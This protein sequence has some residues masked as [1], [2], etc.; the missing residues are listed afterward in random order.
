MEA[1]IRAHDDYSTIDQAGTNE[2][3]P[4]K[5]LSIILD[6][7]SNFQS[8]RLKQLSI[9]SATHYLYNLKQYKDETVE[10]FRQRLK[11]AIEVVYHCGGTIGEFDS[12][13]EEAATDD[14]STLVLAKADE[15]LFD[16]YRERAKDKYAGILMIYLADEARYRK[17]KNELEND[18]TK[19]ND[20][21][22]SSFSEAYSL[23]YYLSLI[24]I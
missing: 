2:S 16:K 21:Y 20:E 8:Q 4:I 6:I 14:G 22:P 24:H 5:L 12:L 9:I 17:L 19:G 23:L 11:N 10:D 15:D 18:F 3:D 7:M 1:K 13:I